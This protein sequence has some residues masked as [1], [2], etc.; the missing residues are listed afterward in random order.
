MF[1]T[2]TD[3][4]YRLLQVTGSAA[5]NNLI[6]GMTCS[7]GGTYRNELLFSFQGIKRTDLTDISF[8]FTNFAN[9]W[10]AITIES[11]RVSSYKT[12]D[13]SGDAQ[14]S[15]TITE[16][17]FYP[18]EVPAANFQISSSSD[19]LG[20]SDPQ[21]T[22]TFKY[23]PASTTSKDGKGIISIRLPNWYNVQGKRNMMFSEKAQ[24][25][26]EAGIDP[27]TGAPDMRIISSTPDVF[28]TSLIIRYD[29]MDPQK[30]AGSEL[31][32]KCKGFKN[33]I[34]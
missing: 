33:P 23:L 27:D 13:C 16:E 3:N 34:F 5:S 18:A 8:Q 24:N 2:D 19:I 21:N 15:E 9:P 32:I 1:K 20:D 31:V 12:P 30:I 28:S 7:I 22:V 25:T 29:Q 10:S 26:C 17:T 11:I 6:D 14:S 4:L